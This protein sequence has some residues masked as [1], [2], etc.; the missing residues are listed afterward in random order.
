MRYR[1]TAVLFFTCRAIALSQP[2]TAAVPTTP[3]HVAFYSY[4]FKTVADPALGPPALERRERMAVSRFGMNAREG[5]ALHAAAVSFAAYLAWYNKEVSNVAGS[6]TLLTTAD[7][8]E[9][10]TFDTQRLQVITQLATTFAQQLTPQTASR[11]ARLMNM[12]VPR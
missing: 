8:A 4:L 11:I 12:E 7:R 9:I 1:L 5:L 2:T 10:A 3:H 6:K